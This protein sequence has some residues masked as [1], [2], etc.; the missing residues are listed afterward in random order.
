MDGVWV[1]NCPQVDALR[2]LLGL[3]GP[4][5]SYLPFGVDSTF[6][7]RGNTLTSPWS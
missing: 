1:L 7:P 5:V 2:D 4:P 3:D 6:S